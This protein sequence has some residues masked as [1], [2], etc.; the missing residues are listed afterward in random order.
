MDKTQEFVKCQYCGDMLEKKAFNVQNRKEAVKKY[1][2]LE[3]IKT[4]KR[5]N[6]PAFS[7]FEYLYTEV[8]GFQSRKEYE[9]KYKDYNNG[10]FFFERA[11]K[12]YFEKLFNGV[13]LEDIIALYKS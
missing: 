11:L 7:T 8:F 5:T 3:T 1:R 4:I 9:A 10:S 6:S 13:S 2:K 12:G